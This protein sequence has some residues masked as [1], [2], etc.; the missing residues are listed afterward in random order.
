MNAAIVSFSFLEIFNAISATNIDPAY[1]KAVVVL[2]AL[3]DYITKLKSVTHPTG[4]ITS[5]TIQ[6]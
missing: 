6:K 3:D 1:G 2:E 4:V 5:Y